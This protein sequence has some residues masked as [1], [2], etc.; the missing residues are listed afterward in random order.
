MWSHTGKGCWW[1]RVITAKVEG[2]WGKETQ[3]VL[4]GRRGRKLYWHGKG[5]KAQ[6]TTSAKTPWSGARIAAGAVCGI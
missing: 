2:M 3:K 4:G 6:R 5:V 1:E